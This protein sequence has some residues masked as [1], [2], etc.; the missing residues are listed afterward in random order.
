MDDELRSVLIEIRDNQREALRRQAEHLEIAREQV[1]R[2]KTQVDES[3]ALQREAIARARTIARFAVPGVI[4]CIA[5]IG[6]L[7]VR[8]L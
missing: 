5:M 6:Y 8:Y 3:L 1:G 2:A 7:I 4:A